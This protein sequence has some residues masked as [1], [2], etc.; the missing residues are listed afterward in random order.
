MQPQPTPG[1]PACGSDRPCESC[2]YDQIK[3]DPTIERPLGNIIDM[4][5]PVFVGQQRTYE[6]GAPGAGTRT[7]LVTRIAG[8]GEV[9]G[10][11]I[12]DRSWILTPAD[13]I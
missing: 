1:C 13:V 7:Y 2:F 10:N 9:Y 5:Q 11:L 8:D 4:L 12:D 3:V 6:V